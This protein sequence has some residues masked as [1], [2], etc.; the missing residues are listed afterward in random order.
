ML[1]LNLRRARQETAVLTLPIFLLINE[2]R[3]LLAN[4]QTSPDSYLILSRVISPDASD[5]IPSRVNHE[6]REKSLISGS[7]S[8]AVSSDGIL[9]L[10]RF[11]YPARRKIQGGG[12]DTI[13]INRKSTYKFIRRAAQAFDVAEDDRRA[14]TSQVPQTAV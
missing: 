10:T 8:R 12:I 11:R 9:E 7:C 13:F 6:S 2:F 3:S 4:G 1:L 5:S 14:V